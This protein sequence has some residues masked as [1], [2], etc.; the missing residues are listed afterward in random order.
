V[1]PTTN[2]RVPVTCSLD[3]KR[4]SKPDPGECPKPQAGKKDQA[5]KA[6]QAVK[7]DPP[8][9]L[10]ASKLQAARVQSQPQAQPQLSSVLSLFPKRQPRRW[11]E[12]GGR[13]GTTGDFGTGEG[14][15]SPGCRWRRQREGTFLAMK[16]YRTQGNFVQPQ[17]FRPMFNSGL[18]RRRQTRLSEGRRLLLI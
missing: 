8:A 13:H 17:M 6:G 7:G 5:G 4:L 1:P 9:R 12:R 14:T 3:I 11:H 18:K 10:S 15:P 16:E 2:P